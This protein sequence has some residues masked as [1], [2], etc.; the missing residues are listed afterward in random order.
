MVIYRSHAIFWASSYRHILYDG[1]AC[2]MFIVMAGKPPGSRD[3][4]GSYPG[5]VRRKE[6]FSYIYYIREHGPIAELVTAGSS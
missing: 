3:R 2:R 1:I 5:R 4:D 6:K